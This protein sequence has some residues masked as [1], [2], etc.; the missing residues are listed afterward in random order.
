MITKEH[1]EKAKNALLE[2]I[3]DFPF[4]APVHQATWVA[5]LLTLVSRHAFSGPAPLFLIEANTPGSAKGL[6]VDV[7]ARI[8]T[9]CDKS[10]MTAPQNDNEFRK[11]ITAIA[12]AGDQLVLI[13]NVTNSLGGSALNA[14][15][16]ATVWQDR[17][18]GASKMTARLPMRSIWAATGNNIELGADTPRRVALIRL[19]SPEENPEDRQGFRHPRLLEWVTQERPRLLAATLTLARGYCLAGRPDMRLR[20]W[21]TFDEWS[22]L[23]RSTVVWSSLPDPGD[24]R[25]E[26]RERH[27]Q[28]LST[29][30]TI[31]AG[32]E[33]LDPDRQGMTSA[34]IHKKL[35]LPQLSDAAAGLKEALLA[36]CMA[37]KPNGPPSPKSIDIVFRKW[38]RE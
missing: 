1:I 35:S 7:A 3:C 13:D 38:I 19:E 26:T 32:V 6:L 15:L 5:L 12:L 21:G 25:A 31:I 27:D 14:A 36:K 34:E 22:D 24:T 10:V 16:T 30:R 2:V 33:D 29:L 11:R 18:L 8:A 37:A 17:I 9:G 4:K 28:E 20:P 23:V